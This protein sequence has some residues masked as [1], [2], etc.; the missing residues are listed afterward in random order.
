MIFIHLGLV[1]LVKQM[2]LVDVDT[3]PKACINCWGWGGYWERGWIDRGLRRLEGGL[4][5]AGIPFFEVCEDSALP[6]LLSELIVHQEL[7]KPALLRREAG[8]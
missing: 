8:G 2:V 6:H 1:R 4:E 5:S 3:S 7:R